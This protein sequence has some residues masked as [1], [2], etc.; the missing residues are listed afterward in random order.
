MCVALYD[1]GRLGCRAI[2]TRLASCR[3]ERGKAEP[4]P[5]TGEASRRKSC[6]V[7][8]ARLVSYS[9]RPIV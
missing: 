4:T 2:A 7:I 1:P 9:C 6:P 3:R 8:A 5:G